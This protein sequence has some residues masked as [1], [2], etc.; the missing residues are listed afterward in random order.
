MPHITGSILSRCSMT[1]AGRGHGAATIGIPDLQG[2]SLETFR[3]G[4]HFLRQ[5]TCEAHSLPDQTPRWV[6]GFLGFLDK[7][8]DW[9]DAEKPGNRSPEAIFLR[10]S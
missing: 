1:Q 4:D 8:I 6:L 5:F 2:T 7:P 10:T 3:I 9:P